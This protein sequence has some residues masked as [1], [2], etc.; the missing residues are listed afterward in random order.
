MLNTQSV[1]LPSELRIK[2]FT[3]PY[4]IATKIDAYLN[5]GNNDFRLSHDIEDI[6]A[7]LD[8]IDIQATFS[9]F[10]GQVKE[11]LMSKFKIFLDDDLFIESVSGHLEQGPVNTSRSKRIIET[12]NN[13]VCA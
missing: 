12:L 1:L 5:R 9:D 10:S 13:F 2:I 3:L 7:I 4:F 6:I 11:Y 8:G